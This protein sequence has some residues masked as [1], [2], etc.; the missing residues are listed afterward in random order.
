MLLCCSNKVEDVL[1]LL[2]P[3]VQASMSTLDSPGM[4]IPP[5]I[6]PIPTTVDAP[7]PYSQIPPS[8]PQPSPLYNPPAPFFDLTESEMTPVEPPLGGLTGVGLSHS[9]ASQFMA[10]V[11]AASS[12]ASSSQQLP[13]QPSTSSGSSFGT[14]MIHFSIEYRNQNIP[15]VLSDTETVGEYIAH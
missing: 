2:Q 3:A 15:L 7:P 1:C 8:F 6:P 12:I 5:P 10:A 4:D 9:A 13:A 11:A 14:R